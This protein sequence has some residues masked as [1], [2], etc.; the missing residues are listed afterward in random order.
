MTQAL[1]F[2][3]NLACWSRLTTCVSS[4]KLSLM[5]NW[6]VGRL[7]LSSLKWQL[8]STE[9]T[10]VTAKLV[11]DLSPTITSTLLSL[12]ERSVKSGAGMACRRRGSAARQKYSRT[13]QRECPLI[14][15]RWRLALTFVELLDQSG[16][17][18]AAAKHI[19]ALSLP[20]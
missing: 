11:A 8:S 17:L 3:F 14:S 19:Q 2:P 4:Y 16:G 5:L 13:S 18:E 15:S 6:L 10:G 20:L 1:L 9:A 12:E 7:R